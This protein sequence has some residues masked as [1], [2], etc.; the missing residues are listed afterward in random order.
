[1]SSVG[2]RSTGWMLFWAVAVSAALH[3]GG[4]QK[5]LPY[6]PESD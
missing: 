5:N 3:L 1:M 4:L 2:L 6:A